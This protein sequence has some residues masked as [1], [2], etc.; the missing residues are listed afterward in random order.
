MCNRIGTA[1]QTG[2]ESMDIPNE[3]VI[4][5][6]IYSVSDV[7][8]WHSSEGVLGL[9]AYRDGIIYIDE[10]L[11]AALSLS[12]LWHESVHIAQQEILGVTEEAQARWISLF[13]HSFLMDNPGIVECY[14]Q[15]QRVTFLDNQ[16]NTPGRES[17][18]EQQ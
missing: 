1:P 3:L 16:T 8:P 5:G 2:R 6:R 18:S 15:A 9:A 4:F 14:R 10:S 12:T 7:T 13:V 17:H 11:D